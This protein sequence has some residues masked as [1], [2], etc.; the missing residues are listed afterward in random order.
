MDYEEAQK[1]FI[2]KAAAALR[3]DGHLILDYDQHS[4]SSAVKFFTALQRAAA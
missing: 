2:R 3:S 4:D 1:T